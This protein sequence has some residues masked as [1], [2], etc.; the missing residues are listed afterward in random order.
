LILQVPVVQVP[1]I[2]ALDFD[3]VICDGRREYVHSGWRTYRQIW[4]SPSATPP[5]GLAERYIALTAVI[6]T[7]LDVPLL[8]R[9]LMLDLPAERILQEWTEL[10]P[11]LLAGVA[12]EKIQT[13][14]VRQRDQWMAEDFNHWLN[15]QPLYPGVTD[16]LQQILASPIKLVI[17]TNRG[18]RFALQLL[19]AAG[20]MIP[21]SQVFG[22]QSDRPKYQVLRQLLTLE[23]SKLWFVEDHVKALRLVKQQPDLAQVELFLADWGFNTPTVRAEMESDPQIHL[24]SLAQFTQPDFSGWL[25]ADC[26]S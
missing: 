16:R 23:D 19:Q 24:L 12:R 14:F 3:G 4:D 2:L 13:E 15:Q 6:E 17:V 22:K 18:Q 7:D 8:V 9:A 11:Q 21:E 20:V 26:N 10:T 25:N 1:D 5:D